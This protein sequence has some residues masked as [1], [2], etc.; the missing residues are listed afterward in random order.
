MPETLVGLRLDKAL[1]ELFPEY[2]RGRLQR[3]LKEG[4]ILVDGQSPRARDKTKGGESIELVK[5]EETGEQGFVPEPVPLEVVHEDDALLIINKPAGLV[6]HPAVG[7]WSGTLMNGL[8]HRYPG[9]GEVPR[10]GIV[11]R[12]DKETSGLMVVA[13][14]LEAHHFLVASLQRRDISREYLALVEGCFV[15]GGTVDEPIGR[16]PVDRKK[17]AV[18]RNGKPAVT[19]YRLRQRYLAHTLLDVKLE[20]GRTHQIRVHMAH[21]RHPIVGDPVYGGRKRIPKGLDEATISVLA[22]FPRQA[23]HAR[24]L[25]LE[26]PVSHELM[27]WEAPVP[28]DMQALLDVLEPWKQ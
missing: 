2:S 13:K 19:H 6:V 25:G 10:A 26:H 4:A 11:H 21:L 20:T 18:V 5:P 16:H 8:L 3:W 17:M 7:N 9:I 27:S 23:L 22:G 14:T 28:E 15:S 1:S 24:R 12:L